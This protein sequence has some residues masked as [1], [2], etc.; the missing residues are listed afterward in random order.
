[1]VN[2]SE[3]LVEAFASVS[4]YARVCTPTPVTKALKLWN[5]ELPSLV[6]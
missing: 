5:S 4:V 1:M 6:F 2:E 3:G